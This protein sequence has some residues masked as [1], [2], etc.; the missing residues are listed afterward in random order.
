MLADPGRGLT[1]ESVRA[2]IAQVTEVSRKRLRALRA[3]ERALVEE[4]AAN[5]NE[6]EAK[7]ESTKSED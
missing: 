7:S 4:A 3:L 1:L 5:T 2:E 6:K